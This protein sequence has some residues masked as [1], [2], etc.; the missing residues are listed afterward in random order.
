MAVGVGEQG[1]IGGFRSLCLRGV[2]QRIGA[3]QANLCVAAVLAL[4]GFGVRQRGIPL[5]G[6]LHLRDQAQIG[7]LRVDLRG[8]LGFVQLLLGLQRQAG[9]GRGAIALSGLGGAGREQQ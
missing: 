9:I 4:E 5:V 7:L 3:L 1:A 2:A 8:L 6:L